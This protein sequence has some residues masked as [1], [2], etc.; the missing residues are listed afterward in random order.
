MRLSRGL[1]K[2]V[3][4]FNDDALESFDLKWRRYYKQEMESKSVLDIGCGPAAHSKEIM[5]TVDASSFFG[6]DISFGLLASAA[7]AYPTYYFCVAD[8][9]NLPFHN[10]SIDVVIT[11]FTFHHI[12]VA[13]RSLA[14]KE[15][16]R[17]SRRVVILRDVFGV[18]KGFLGSL[19]KYY[20]SIVDG[21]FHRYTLR[22]Q[23]LIKSHF[24]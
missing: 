3:F 6:V 2:R 9:S 15:L 13:N 16:M 21:S 10:K 7:I 23:K 22:I 4:G 8:A 19:Y 11:N 24:K 14:L 12:E 18:G 1:A 20:Y 17:V 5:E